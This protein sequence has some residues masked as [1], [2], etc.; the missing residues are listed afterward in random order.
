MEFLVVNNDTKGRLSRFVIKI[1]EKLEPKYTFTAYLKVRDLEFNDK[2]TEN[3][4]EILRRLVQKFKESNLLSYVLLNI[5]IAS[6][7]L[8]ME[9]MY[10]NTTDRKGNFHQNPNN[11]KRYP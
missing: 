3:L 4:L 2:L 8:L 7:R 10:K 6:N 5:Q 11:N 9:T 1:L